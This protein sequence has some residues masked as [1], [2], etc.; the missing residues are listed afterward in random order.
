VAVKAGFRFLPPMMVASAA[1]VVY[2]AVAGRSAAPEHVLDG[3]DDLARNLLEG[4]GLSFDAGP[5]LTRGP[6]YPAWL[7]V[8]L[9]V[10][11]GGLAAVRALEALVI[12]G[13]CW[14][15]YSA[16]CRWASKS[17]ALLAAILVAFHP[18][19]VYYTWKL[20]SEGLSTLIFAASGYAAARAISSASFL[21]SACFGVAAGIAVLTKASFAVLLPVFGAACAFSGL[22]S[23]RAAGR[24]GLA[25]L[26]AAAVISPWVLR[27]RE[28]AGTA[29]P[30]QTLAWWNFWYDFDYDRDRRAGALGEGGAR[31][32]SFERFGS[33]YRGH[34]YGLTAREDVEQERFLRG[35]ALAW[36]ARNPGAF[37]FKFA[38]N[39]WQFWTE[40]GARGGPLLPA[41]RLAELALAFVGAASLW[42]AGKRAAGV[43]GLGPPMALALATAPFFS[44]LRHS[45]PS[46][47]LL[48]PLEAE[49]ILHIG[50]S[51]R[52]RVAAAA[53]SRAGVLVVGPALED[54][55]GIAGVLSTYR[56][57]GL[58]EDETDGLAIR[59]FAST[60]QGPL[61]RK[62]WFPLGRFLRF[63]FG[64]GE[65][66]ALVHLNAAWRGSFY[67]KAAYLWTAKAKGAR[68]LFHLHPAAFWDFYDGSRAPV[69]AFI[70][71][72]LRRS[73]RVAVV[74]E[75]LAL[76]VREVLPSARIEILPNP[77]DLVS[78]AIE[79]V[80]QRRA[81]R[82]AYA[83]WLVREKGV[84][85]LLEAYGILLGRGLRPEL[86]L[87]GS[88]GEE[89]VKKRISELGLEEAPI[90]VPGW[91]DR[92]SLAEL[93]HTCA[94]FALP[95]YTEG[96]PN[97]LL[98]AMACGASVVTCP[99]GGIPS[100]VREGRNGLF[101]EPGN[102]QALASALERLLSDEAERRKMSEAN[103]EDVR[104]FDARKLVPLLRRLYGEMLGAG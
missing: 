76:R 34:P 46:I 26:A 38:R 99:V 48:A 22:G 96:V 45:V 8:E 87:A 27:N 58:F 97:A 24:A 62:L 89:E 39:V 91:L 10:G 77:V 68:V 88:P 93:F 41:A 79:P 65:K 13:S 40:P 35:E 53:G 36:I 31:P 20:G 94:I 104:A 32:L 78:L 33:S 61:S 16:T 100:I 7:A 56:A 69:R 83:G 17:T 98:E 72:T 47:A 18:L 70:R 25:V 12:V 73:D 55:G 101:V 57:A 74:A 51:I 95:S 6:V 21:W 71:A 3:Y 84:F 30:L 86:V 1:A 19:F 11:G 92:R 29:A 44:V 15:C 90:L 64:R 23:K 28:V 59:T 75:P 85:D 60:R 5:T 80:P 82:I 14:F 43:W 66:I 49:G 54:R 63:A 102:V 37:A 9:L 4:R 52:R 2:L 42:R 50:R 67:R 81:D 103:R